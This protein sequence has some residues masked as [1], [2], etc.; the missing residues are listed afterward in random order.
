MHLYG[1][2]HESDCF[3][4]VSHGNIKRSRYYIQVAEEYLMTYPSSSKIK[5]PPS[6]LYWTHGV[7]QMPLHGHTNARCAHAWNV[8]WHKWISRHLWA[9]FS[10]EYPVCD[11]SF[12]VMV[13][14]WWR[15]E[16]LV[17]TQRAL[18]AEMTIEEVAHKVNCFC[19][20]VPALHVYSQ[21]GGPCSLQSP[22]RADLSFNCNC[23][24]WTT[25]S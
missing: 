5:A 18:K 10:P 3:F 12:A 4:I 16:V 7:K 23:V 22:V 15:R 19:I 25:C 11:S 6:F 13:M 14:Y 20:N 9:E 21:H 2:F 24:C 17:V 1:E 8:R